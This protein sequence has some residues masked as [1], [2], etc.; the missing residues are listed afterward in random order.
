MMSRMNNTIKALLIGLLIVGLY[1]AASVSYTTI[2]GVAPCPAV[3]FVPA[4]FVVFV[5]YLLMLVVTIVM[6]QRRSHW[7]FLVGWV[8]VFL[9]AF[10]GSLF[11]MANGATCPKSNTG[12]ALCY[13]SLNFAVVVVAL[14]AFL[15]KYRGVKNN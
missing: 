4:C 15:I 9:L 5:G 13:V 10:I 12:L 2:T 1:G 11:E 6:A 14:Y 8:S 3:G 7:L